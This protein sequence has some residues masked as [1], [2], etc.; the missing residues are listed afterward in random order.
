MFTKATNEL[1]RGLDRLKRYGNVVFFFTSNLVSGLDPAFI[2][3]CCIEKEINAPS[4]DCTFEI[5]RMEVNSLIQVGIISFQTLVY[6]DSH[7]VIADDECNLSSPF[8]IEGPGYNSKLSAIPSRQ[9]AS[10]HWAPNTTTAVSELFRI[11]TLGK[12]LSGRKLKGLVGCARYE[13]MV[14]KPGDLRDLLQALEAV[15]REKTRQPRKGVGEVD[16]N[17]TKSHGS[18][19]TAEDIEK[20]LGGLEGEAGSTDMRN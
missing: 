1:L 15:I 11:A 7:S 10:I 4:A 12:G 16:A 20:F 17:V 18:M 9:W 6:E 14:D 8:L 13:Y 3:R 2:D 19:G 5:L